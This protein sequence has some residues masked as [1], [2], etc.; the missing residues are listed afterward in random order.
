VSARF[1]FGQDAAI[2][3]SRFPHQWSFRYVNIESFAD[4]PQLIE[5]LAPE[6]AHHWVSGVIGWT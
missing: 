5:I 2:M 6:I 3:V 4:H 1:A